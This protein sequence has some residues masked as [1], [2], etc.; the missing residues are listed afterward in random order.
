MFKSVFV[1][2]N[3]S[4]TIIARA[5]S[6]LSKSILHRW[7]SSNNN[8]NNNNNNTFSSFS[9]SHNESIDQ[10]RA[11]LTYQS[12]KR[13]ILETDL[14]LSTFAKKYLN[15]FTERELDEYDELLNVPDWDIYHFAVDQKPVPERWSNS[16]VF[17]KLRT[18]VKNEG[19]EILRM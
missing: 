9:S 7:L 19:K 5:N 15:E 4:N 2:I 16:E 11:R 6:S 18:H 12:R 1:T 8:N 10:K 3:P 14:L 17:K 13:G